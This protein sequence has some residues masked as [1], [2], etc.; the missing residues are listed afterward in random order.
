MI[1]E[2]LNIKY[3]HNVYAKSEFEELLYF[4]GLKRNK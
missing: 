3:I 1:T 4:K 2:T